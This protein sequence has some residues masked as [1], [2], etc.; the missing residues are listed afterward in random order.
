MLKTNSFLILA[1]ALIL[2]PIPISPRC[3][4]S[5]QSNPHQPGA[6]STGIYQNLFT[7]L[8]GFNDAQV[9]AR[10]DSAFAQLFYGDD[11]TQRVYYPVD[12]DMAFIEDV[13]HRDVRTEGMSYGM[14]IAVQMDKKQEFNR[15]WK[16][17]K[18]FMQHPS[19]PNKGYFA[20]HCD[21]TGSM[22]DSNAASDGEEWFVTALFFASARWGDGEGIYRYSHEAQ[23]ILNAMLHK[24]EEPGVGG[25]ITAMFDKKARQVVFVPVVEASWFTDPSYHVPHFYEIWARMAENDN[26][27][28]CQAADTSRVFLQRVTNE[29]TGLAPDYAHFDGTP[30]DHWN[31]GHADFRFDAW[32]VAMNVAVDYSWF[33]RDQWAVNECNRLLAFFAGQGPG[34]YGNQ[35]TL[36]GKML[37][38]DHSTGLV[39]MNAVAC[40]A[41][42]SPGRIGFVRELWNVRVPRGPFRYYDGLLYLLGM[43]QV[44]GNFR[45]YLPSRGLHMEKCP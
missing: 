43:L 16:W 33:G 17:A 24:R 3:A 45:A 21:T 44:S 40:L 22:I 41:A 27:F 4:V 15:L 14:M 10:V 18:T 9:K 20:W 13:L 28:W 2:S 23:A 11:R 37:G 5:G 35:Y 39:A 7:E 26:E 30:L 31:G 32:R 12:R 19:G 38:G 29:R 36:E 34:R 25:K 6:V 42:D 1:T 8:L